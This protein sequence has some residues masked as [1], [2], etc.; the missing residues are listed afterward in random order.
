MNEYLSGEKQRYVEFNQVENSSLV[1][2][3]LAALVE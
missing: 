2:A 3:A 1:G